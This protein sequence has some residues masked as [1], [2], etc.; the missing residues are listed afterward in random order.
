MILIILGTLAVV[1]VAV[2]IGMLINRKTPLLAAP[3]DFE[4]EAQRAR[5]QLVSHG[6][7]EA[8]ATALRVRAPQ[9]EK[10]RTTQRC[11]S[12]RAAMGSDDDDTVRY[13]DRDLLVLHFT[14]PACAATR[15]LYIVPVP[16]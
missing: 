7:G 16:T 11:P 3:E 13:D 9:I 12:C 4:T 15:S 2:A 14:C 5:K 6:A 8:P 10:L 1:G